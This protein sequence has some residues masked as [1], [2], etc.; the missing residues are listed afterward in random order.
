MRRILLVID[1]YTELIYIQSLLK[2]IGFNVDGVQSDRGFEEAV[3]RT[4]PDLVIFSLR[5]KNFYGIELMSQ[6][7]QVPK[8][9]VLA[10]RSIVEVSDAIA[11]LAQAGKVLE[12]PVQAVQLLTAL[13]EL[14]SM[15][16][17]TLLAKYSKIRSYLPGVREDE[18]GTTNPHTP[19]SGEE[20]ASDRF[21]S[22]AREER[23]KAVLAQIQLPAENGYSRKRVQDEVK[24]TRAVGSVAGIDQERRSFVKKLFNTKT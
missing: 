19:N 1:H 5:N 24:Q 21:H 7:R 3:L 15:D 13:A 16:L 17:Q 22:A 23:M 6:V 8:T 14:G 4:N 11:D 9:I 12:T 20:A 18:A 2:K 10:P